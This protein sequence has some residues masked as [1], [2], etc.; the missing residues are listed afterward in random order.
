MLSNGNFIISTTSFLKQ[1]IKI[2]LFPLWLGLWCLAVGLLGWYLLRWW[3]GDRL[4]PVRFINYFTPWLLLGLM[5]GL[6]ITLLARRYRLATTLALPTL[7]ISLTYAPLFLP[8]PPAALAANTPLKVMS[9]NVWG[10]N[11]KLDEVIAII[12]QEQ[13]DILLLQEA[14]WPSGY[15]LSSA[16]ADLYPNSQTYVAY[17]LEMGQLII[18]RYPLIPTEASYKKGRA[19]K[20]QVNTPTGTIAVWNVHT[21]QPLTWKEQYRQIT[22]L[23][24]DIAQTEIPLIVGGDFNT[25][26]QAENYRLI[27]QYLSNAHWEAGWGFGFSFPAHNPRYNR[28][29]VLTPMVRI[30]HIFYSSHFFARSAQ[31]LTTSGGSD[32]LPVTAQLSQVE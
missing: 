25:T 24:A 28:I 31:T 18:S 22:A 13:P 11:H 1:S 29:P 12:H 14:Y 6:A 26:E 27:N 20:V 4:F 30:D 16:L 17:E 5:P 8:R 2:L 9:Y 7:L 10:R 3:P 21:Y 23:T 15:N 32:H 19:Q